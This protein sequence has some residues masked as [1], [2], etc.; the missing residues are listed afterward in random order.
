[1]CYTSLIP[2]PFQLNV[3][4]KKLPGTHCFDDVTHS[5]DGGYGLYV[6]CSLVGASPKVLHSQFPAGLKGNLPGGFSR[7]RLVP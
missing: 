5:Y 7:L 1:M 2:R 6:L 4:E 3:W